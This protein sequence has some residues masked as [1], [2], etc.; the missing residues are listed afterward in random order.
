MLQSP[1]KLHHTEEALP[2]SL[3]SKKLHPIDKEDTNQEETVVKLK[4]DAVHDILLKIKH[5]HPPRE[6]SP[7]G[8]PGSHFRSNI[9]ATPILPEQYL[10]FLN[11]VPSLPI[12]FPDYENIQSGSERNRGIGRNHSPLSGISPDRRGRETSYVGNSMNTITGLI[13]NFL[14]FIRTRCEIV[15]REY[16]EYHKL[17]QK[18]LELSKND[19]A[20]SDELGKIFLKGREDLCGELFDGEEILRAFRGVVLKGISDLSNLV[21][22]R[23]ADRRQILLNRRQEVELLYEAYMNKNDNYKIFQNIQL[24]NDEERPLSV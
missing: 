12:N 1:Q 2:D 5:M 11:Y 15:Y 16:D 21:D 23:I 19:P 9:K 8:S 18:L 14:E 24:S 3:A 6:G 4:L 17:L 13:N 7:Q 20:L 10:D 22:Q